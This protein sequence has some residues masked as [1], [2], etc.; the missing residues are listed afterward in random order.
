MP[1]VA[2]CL[3]AGGWGLASAFQSPAQREAAAAPPTPGPVT[4]AVERGDLV[5]TVSFAAEVARAEKLDVALA[6][7]DE[8]RTYITKSVSSAGEAVGAGAV[9]AEVNGRPVFVVAGLFPFYR[10]LG[11]GDTGPDVRQ[12]QAGLAAA[13]LGSGADGVFGDVTARAVRGLYDRAGYSVPEAP[14]TG[15]APEEDA[16]PRETETSSVDTESVGV[17]RRVLV[18]FAELTV[19]SALPATVVTAPPEG[20]KVTD[21]SRIVLGRGAAILR[22]S[23]PRLASEG[24]TSATTGSVAIAGGEPVAVSVTSVT[25]EPE[26]ED[27]SVRLKPATT[28]LGEVIG[29]SG[30]VVLEVEVVEKDALLVPSVAVAGG[31]GAGR[32]HLLVRKR[33]GEFHRI[34]VQEL[35]ELDGLSAV[36]PLDADELHESDRVRVG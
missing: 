1:L 8:A 7:R 17:A 30:V 5:R 31:G 26:A 29:Q 9:V 36:E 13:G 35:G 18:P 22:G 4:A 15:S 11:E 2:L 12:L 32:S 21:E 33:T 34:A 25:G 20:A 23:I 14:G 10:D 3:V 16:A 27:R 24:I 28:G 6:P 19:A